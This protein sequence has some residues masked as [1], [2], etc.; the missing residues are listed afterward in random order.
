MR[1]FS[2]LYHAIVLR[3]QS[4][5][6]YSHKKAVCILR[7]YVSTS[8]SLSYYFARSRRERESKS[9]EVCTK[10]TLLNGK[11]LCTRFLYLG[12]LCIGTKQRE[13]EKYIKDEIC[14]NV[15]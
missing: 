7:T 15:T 11:Y 2:K 12:Y 13:I 1:W 8:A 14:G 6:G 10:Q 9:A 3:L 5:Q 4:E